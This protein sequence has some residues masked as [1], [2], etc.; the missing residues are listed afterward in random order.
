M[1]HVSAAFR[2]ARVIAMS[3]GLMVLAPPAPVSSQPTA[4]LGILLTGSPATPAP[5]TDLLLQRLAALGWVEGRTLAVE[6]RWAEDPGQ[7]HRPAAELVAKK[8]TVIL[9]PG[10]QATREPRPRPSPS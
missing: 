5:A 9:A 7:F 6:R 1:C 4:R 3:V 2:Y 10:A 8:V